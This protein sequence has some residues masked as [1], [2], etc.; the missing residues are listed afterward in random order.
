MRPQAE[1]RGLPHRATRGPPC[2]KRAPPRRGGG[3]CRRTYPRRRAP[4]LRRPCRGETP[5]RSPSTGSAHPFGVRST[6]GYTPA[7]LRDARCRRAGVRNRPRAPPRTSCAHLGASGTRAARPAM[8]APGP[9]GSVAVPR[10]RCAGPPARRRWA[11]GRCAGPPWSRAAS[12]R[13]V[14]T[15][16]GRVG[17]FSDSLGERDRPL[18][19]R[20]DSAGTRDKPPGERDSRA[21][22]LSSPSGG[23]DRPS[24][25]SADSPVAWRRSAPEP[26][27]PSFPWPSRGVAGGPPPA[28]ARDPHPPR[29]PVRPPRRPSF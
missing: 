14:G 23:R 20:G 1:R 6:R 22:A 27:R 26:P 7:S 21:G 9:P 3:I 12:L 28:S 18:G 4:R 25:A 17:A 10:W 8:R 24:V 16:S 29:N 2:V 11:P 15:R 13:S 19:R 5:P